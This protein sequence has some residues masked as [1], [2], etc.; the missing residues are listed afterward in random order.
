MSSSV[1]HR[2]ATPPNS[3]S[4]ITGVFFLNLLFSTGA[5]FLQ[6]QKFD[7]AFL[8]SEKEGNCCTDSLTFLANTFEMRTDAQK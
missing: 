8:S 2:P 4:E 3:A 5:L 7:F 1:F 6:A